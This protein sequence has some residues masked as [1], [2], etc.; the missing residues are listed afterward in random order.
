M[1][2]YSISYLTLYMILVLLFTACK[3]QDEFL[4]ARTNINLTVP[5]TINDFQQL[6]NNENLFNN[7]DPGLGTLT[8]EEFYPINATWLLASTVDRNAYMFASDIYQGSGDYSDWTAPYQAIYVCNVVLDGIAN[9]DISSENKATLQGIK[10]RALFYRAWK[11]FGLLQTFSLPG[12][13]S[14]F[15]NK[16][17]IPL[18]LSSDFNEKVPRSKIKTCYDQIIADTKEAAA[19][20]PTTVQ[21]PTMPSQAAAYG[22]LARVYLSLGNYDSAFLYSDNA[23]QMTNSLTDYNEVNTAAYPTFSSGY[24]AEDIFHSTIN[25]YNFLTIG[26]TSVD[27]VLL[28]SYNVNDLRREAFFTARPIG[29]ITFK[30]TYDYK[31][32]AYSG[33]ATDELY[34]TRAECEARRGNILSALDDINHLLS[35]RFKTGSY[36]PLSITDKDDIIDIVLMERRRELIFRGLR[37]LD[38]RRLNIKSSTAETLLRH[39]AS[40][41]YTLA[42]KDSKYAMPIPPTEIEL[43]GISQNQ[44]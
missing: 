14:T 17:G 40:L 8:S 11:F 16:D 41:A 18:R 37:W 4:D 1:K 20:L 34:L 10:G 24:V 12:D 31:R 3:K 2:R 44:R 36:V 15:T 29:T 42:P 7:N 35:H 33:I 39:F 26:Y 38:L 22:F 28:A 32:R 30:G 13:S 9:M 43:S 19:L 27:S 6:L 23:L 21:Y 5:S 25:P